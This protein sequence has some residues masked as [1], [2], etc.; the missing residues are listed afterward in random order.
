MTNAIQELEKEDLL[1]IIVDGINASPDGAIPFSQYMEVCLTSPRGY[2][3][4]GKAE[5]DNLRGD[6]KTAPG[7]HP[8]LEELWHEEYMMFG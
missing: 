6:F 3:G 2:Y 7:E 5:I 1:Q 4:A 8:I